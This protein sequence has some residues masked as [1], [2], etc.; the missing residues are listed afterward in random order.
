M[1]CSLPIRI[2]AKQKID[3]TDTYTGETYSITHEDGH[4]IVPCGNC[5]QCRQRR[6]NDWIMRLSAEDKNYGGGLFATL[7]YSPD[8]L[9]N[10]DDYYT[11]QKQEDG[12]YKQILHKGAIRITEKGLMTVNKRDIQLFM[13]RI[14]KFYNSKHTIKYYAA[15]E[16]GETSYRPHYHIII[17]GVTREDI[18]R[19]WPHGHCHVGSVTAASISYSTKYISKPKMIP[20]Y[21][22][23]DRTPEFSLMS[24]N[25]GI[26]YLT[27]EVINYHITNN[28]SHYLKEGGYPAPLP[29]YYRDKIFNQAQKDLQNEEQQ[30][31]WRLLYEKKVKECGSELEYARIRTEYAW[32]QK[33]IFKNQK[34]FK[35]P[36]I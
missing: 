15:A 28:Q 33:Q 17:F 14:R 20:Q 35:K 9:H 21:G 16:Y 23:D 5:P 36:T 13:K 4:R 3:Y 29:R 18:T 6:I 8:T 1:S 24:K 32:R 30:V 19:S 10:E 7:T 26:C 2:R 34:S 27:Q 25:L 22:G 12:T 11:K 31:R